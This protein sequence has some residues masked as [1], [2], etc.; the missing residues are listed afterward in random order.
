[1][2]CD[3]DV[4]GNNDGWLD[5]ND[6][7]L[8]FT[9]PDA[10]TDN[11][12]HHINQNGPITE[13]DVLELMFDRDWFRSVKAET[14]RYARQSQTD[15]QRQTWSM[16]TLEEMYKFFAVIVHMS[17][18]HKP[19]VRDYFST[20][21]ILYSSFP[22]QI[23]LGRDRFMSI[24]KYLHLNDNSTYIP[25]GEP[26]HDPLHKV[27]PMVDLMN[28]KF[29]TLYTPSSNLTLDEAM[30]PFRGRLGFKV[31][32]KNKP[33]KYG[34]RLEV[35]ADA[36]NGVV[37]HFEAYTGAAANVSNTVTDLVIRMLS[38]FQ[39]KNFK[40]FMDRRY[41]SP[42]LFT[43]LR[44]QGFYPVG[45]VMKNRRGLPKC[46]T[47]KL[48]KGET[49]FRRK[50]D[51][52]ALKWKDK[53]DVFLLSSTDKAVMVQTGQG[54]DE[55]AG[56]DHE[57]LK[58]AAIVRYNQNKAGVD[59]ADQMAS[60]YPMHRKTVKWWKKM[61]FGLFTMSLINLNKYRNMKNGTATKLLTFL[62]AIGTQL[63]STQEH[64]IPPMPAAAAEPRRHIEHADHFPI[65][66]E[67]TPGKA[68]P[69]RQC[70]LC[71]KKRN[72]NNK[73]VRRESSWSCKACDVVLC[74]E[75]FLPYHRR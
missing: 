53:R 34:V 23:G 18:V 74:V 75:C 8:D 48:T 35:V 19:S 5:V 62:M 42:N 7:D 56:G 14:N 64:P 72:A 70:V 10:Y 32:M 45:T 25:R 47:Q 49:L 71:S 24:M 38:P 37:L 51:V 33:N 17:I 15:A 66:L 3:A 41:S 43:Q 67:P 9:E 59:R 40:V 27:R 6:D 1:M 69:T 21:P 50:G 11:Q 12:S 61:F 20:T 58:P 2:C 39:G 68:K 55:R 28:D 44:A 13:M 65:R 60:Y 31:Y 26:N 52:L 4:D 29:K 36:A 46:F 57:T 30:I 63:G 22:S 54:R 16:V 73:P